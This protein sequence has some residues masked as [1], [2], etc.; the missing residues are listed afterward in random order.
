MQLL[1][2]PGK[3]DHVAIACYEVGCMT[4]E[5][6]TAR[7]GS[8]TNE[9]E[10]DMVDVKVDLKWLNYFIKSASFLPKCSLQLSCLP[11]KHFARISFVKNV[12]LRIHVNI[13]HE[14]AFG[15]NSFFEHHMCVSRVSGRN[16]TILYFVQTSAKWKMKFQIDN[17]VGSSG[18]LNKMVV[19][20]IDNILKILLL[21][22]FHLFF[23]QVTFC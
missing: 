11:P 23:W 16:K 3:L 6:S 7:F 5:P 22:S 19:I 8:Q 10:Y 2:V 17:S 20:V 14:F 15:F 13:K 21:I 18:V 12:F 1:D 4:P 9:N